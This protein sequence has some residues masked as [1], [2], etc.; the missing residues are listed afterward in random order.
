[1]SI[2]R[3]KGQLNNKKGKTEVRKFNFKIITS[4]NANLII[5]KS[6]TFTYNTIYM[7]KNKI[8]GEIS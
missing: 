7:H 8:C 3:S 5:D 1:M 6:Y 4:V 2:M